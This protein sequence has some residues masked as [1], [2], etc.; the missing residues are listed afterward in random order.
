MWF[1]NELYDK[2]R[3]FSNY[4]L[5]LGTKISTMSKVLYNFY[6]Q[7]SVDFSKKYEKTIQ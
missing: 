4:M 5:G 7:H 1:K 6:K 2:A 3:I